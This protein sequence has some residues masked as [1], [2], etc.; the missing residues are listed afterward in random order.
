[1]IILAALCLGALTGWMRGRAIQGN[2]K[3]R[4]LYAAVHAIL[5]A[6]AAVFAAILLD[7]L[8]R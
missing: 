6:L 7:R 4:A 5:F 1:M 2:A 8:G 3:D